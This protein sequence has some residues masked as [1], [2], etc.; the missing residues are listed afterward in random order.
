[1]REEKH[2]CLEWPASVNSYESRAS[3]NCPACLVS[4]EILTS[5]VSSTLRLVNMASLF[6]KQPC[7]WCVLG[8]FFFPEADYRMLCRWSKQ[9]VQALDSIWEVYGLNHVFAWPRLYSGTLNITHLSPFRR[10]M[11]TSL[12]WG[13]AYDNWHP[14]EGVKKIFRIMADKITALSALWAFIGWKKTTTFIVLT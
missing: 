12:L 14:V 6:P 3:L 8:S 7:I 1:M 13:K 9:L 4:L 11:S 10:E 5:W 2:F